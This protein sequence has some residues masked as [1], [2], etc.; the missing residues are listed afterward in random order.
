M[1][2]H[3]IMKKTIHNDRVKSGRVADLLVKGKLKEARQF[4]CRLLTVSSILREAGVDRI[5]L[6]KID[7]EKS[8]LHV[9]RGIDELDW[10]KIDQIVMET[11]GEHITE[12]VTSLLNAKGF[13]VNTERDEQFMNVNIATIFAIRP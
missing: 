10:P 12:S 3:N 13:K 6:L 2:T 8:E 5:D 7:V 11:H 9:L 4:Q 1:G